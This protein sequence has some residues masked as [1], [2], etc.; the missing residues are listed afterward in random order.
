MKQ[1]WFDWYMNQ[2]IEIGK[3]FKITPKKQEI[4]NWIVNALAFLSPRDIIKAFITSGIS[5]SM[6]G[7]EDHIAHNVLR[8][9]DP[10]YQEEIILTKHDSLDLHEY[11]KDKYL[12]NEDIEPY[13][14]RYYDKIGENKEELVLDDNLEN[15][16]D[17]LTLKEQGNDENNEVDT[18]QVTK[19]LKMT[20]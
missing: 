19:R 10:T 7:E 4:Y 20:D 5:V 11:F 17:L 15:Y 1:N 16:L 9:K 2:S 3:E 14:S 12:E 8:L 18:I 13:R 6:K